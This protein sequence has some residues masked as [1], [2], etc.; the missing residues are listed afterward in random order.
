M[1]ASFPSADGYL[2]TWMAWHF[3]MSFCVGKTEKVRSGGLAVFRKNLHP[4][5]VWERNLRL[6]GVHCAW[7]TG[8]TDL[9]PCL[10]SKTHF[11]S[12]QVVKEPH[13]YAA[14]WGCLWLQVQAGLSLWEIPLVPAR[15][16]CGEG[17]SR[18][19]T[20]HDEDRLHGK[21]SNKCSG[22]TQNWIIM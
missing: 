12:H 22:I 17:G 7:G 11:G 2:I 6:S 1:L 15:G 18:M 10:G 13:I 19:K 9:L 16:W 4:Q 5:L 3:M 8:Q 14:G 20:A 21:D